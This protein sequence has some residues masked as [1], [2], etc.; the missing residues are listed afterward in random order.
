MSVM[1]AVVG[2]IGVVLALMTVADLVT[3]MLV[4]R[5]GS[6]PIARAVSFLVFRPY[7]LAVR[8]T[9]SFPR[10]DRILA[11]AAP[12]A[13]LAQLIAYVAILI[14][15]LGLVVYAVSPLDLTTALY[16][17][18]STRKFTSPRCPLTTRAETMPSAMRLTSEA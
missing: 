14:V 13:L 2:L 6:V 7:R 18:A 8:L 1:R 5:G 12:V 16:Q 11:S 15:A 3:A 4:P 9:S 17:S 10:Q